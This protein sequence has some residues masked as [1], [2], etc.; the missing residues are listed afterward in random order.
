MMEELIAQKV[1]LELPALNWRA[2]LVPLAQTEDALARLDEVLQASPIREGWISRSHYAEACASTA[3]DGHLVPIEELVL[4]QEEMGMITP[5]DGVRQASFVLSA[6]ER[7]ASA[8]PSWAMSRPGL[9]SL[10]GKAGWMKETPVSQREEER[11]GEDAA[12]TRFDLALSAIDALLQRTSQRLDQIRTKVPPPP[13]DAPEHDALDHWRA[14]FG[15]ASL[16]PPTLAAVLL[17]D[18][19][20]TLRP[21][22]LWLGRQIA[23]AYLRHSGKTR[24]LPGLALGLQRQAHPRSRYQPLTQ[25]AEARVRETLS[26]LKITAEHGLAEHQ[27]LCSIQDS[28][29]RKT[30]GRRKS[31]HLPALIAFVL[32]RPV[33]TSASAAEALGIS[34]RKTLDLIETLGLRELTERGRFRAWAVL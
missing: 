10:V 8:R 25:P 19:W 4:R 29:L 13:I 31:S 3:L 1:R 12:E 24:F 22:P 34:Q 18:A 17:H 14:L 28:L 6:R 7:M 21:G 30:V 11:D 23:A 5:H 9:E 15:E 26:G 16:L 20:L 27:R 33:I 2:L 32:R